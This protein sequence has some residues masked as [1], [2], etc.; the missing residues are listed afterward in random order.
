MQ[1]DGEV[2]QHGI[3]VLM[4]A[5]VRTAGRP[6]DSGV[7]RLAVLLSS[8]T[9]YVMRPRH[10]TTLPEVPGTEGRGQSS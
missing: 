5:T 3:S 9:L 6:S 4:E 1:V 10:E 7:Q 8:Q 2:I